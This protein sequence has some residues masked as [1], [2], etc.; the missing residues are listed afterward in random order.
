MGQGR[1]RGGAGVGQGRGRGQECGT[2]IEREQSV[3][4]L[5]IAV[6]PLQNQLHM[7]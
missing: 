6:C 5:N 1:G 3:K 7:Q 4:C 2:C